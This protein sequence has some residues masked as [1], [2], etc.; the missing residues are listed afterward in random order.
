MAWNPLGKKPFLTARPA[1]SHGLANYLEDREL[2]LSFVNLQEYEDHAKKLY[3]E[4]K[5]YEECVVQM[6]KLEQKMSSEM[7]NSPLCHDDEELKKIAEDYQSVAYQMGHC[8]DDLVQLSQKTVVEP[9]KKLTTE[10]EAIAADIK[11]RDLALADAQKCQAKYEKLA[12]AEKTGAN[13]VKAEA[14]KKAF[15]SS[16]DE[17]DHQNRL[18]VMELPQF[19]EKR[20]DYFQP[21]LQ[22]LIRSQVDYY[23]ET[24]RLF[25]HLVSA[26]P[27]AASIKSDEKCHE[28]VDA[29]LGEIRSLSI[30]RT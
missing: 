15:Q 22:A 10:F 27:S 1:L 4:V 19:Y 18:L 24:T 28:E 21:C 23:G 30:V 25:T 7:S 5:R 16:K 29:L 13:V 8:T 14:A 17:F 2:E 12:K 9:M 26:N 11:K 20:V 3:K 6:H